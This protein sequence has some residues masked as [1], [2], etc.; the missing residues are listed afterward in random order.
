MNPKWKCYQEK[1]A[2]KYQEQRKDESW[3]KE[4]ALKKSIRYDNQVQA[5]YD[6]KVREKNTKKK[7]RIISNQKSRKYVVKMNPVK[8]K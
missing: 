7:W 5:E 6:D 3:M 4:R 2:K 8:E 1:V